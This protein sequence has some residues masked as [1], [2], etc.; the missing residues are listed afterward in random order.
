[1]QIEKPRPIDISGW[2]K[3]KVNDLFEVG[4][5][6]TTP[7]SEII[8]NKGKYPYVTTQSSNNGVRDYSSIKTEKGNVLVV[9]SAVLG[10]MT[11]QENDFSAS[12]HVEKLVPKF[13]LNKNSGLFIASVWNKI[14]SGKF[15]NYKRKASQ[16]AIRECGIPLP[17]DKEGNLDYEYMDKYMGEIIERYGKFSFE[18]LRIKLKKDTP[19][20]I[21][22]WREFNLSGENGIFELKNSASKIHNKN[23]LDEKGKI[24]Y[25][26]RT[27]ENNGVAKHIKEQKIEINKGNCLTLGMDA[28]TI[29]YQENDFYT[30]DKIK[31]LRNDNLNKINSLFLISIIR[32]VIKQN[33][34][35]GGKGMNFKELK[36]IKILLPVDSKGNPDWQFMEDYIKSLPYSKALE[37]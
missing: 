22:E 16:T 33:F 6:V 29:F 26:T 11:Y 36:K 25:V 4:G 3:F 9:D 37:N 21:S 7:F 1:M 13:P 19:L 5:T 28:V 30:G 17:I 15:F 24:P 32:K 35:W 10:W 34:S 18:K 27:A 12:D 31:I 8:N 23:I 2:R 14:Y 20:N